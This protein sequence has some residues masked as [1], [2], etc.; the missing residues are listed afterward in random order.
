MR[1]FF[2]AQ[3]YTFHPSFSPF[4]PLFPSLPYEAECVPC[5]EEFPSV[6]RAVEPWSVT[7]PVGE[8]PGGGDGPWL[9]VLQTH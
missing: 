4:M 1:V 6:S 2:I 9:C 5:V 7:A 3:N 8:I